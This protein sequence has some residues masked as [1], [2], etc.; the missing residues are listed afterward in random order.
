MNKPNID[1]IHYQKVERHAK[2]I[3]DTENNGCM[4]LSG[5]VLPS[6]RIYKRVYDVSQ[7][8]HSKLIHKTDKS[9]IQ[10]KICVR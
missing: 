5:D 6:R 10:I 3:S 8:N 2:L 9:T 7:N 4:S 1:D